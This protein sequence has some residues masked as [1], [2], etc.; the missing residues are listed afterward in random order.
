VA[1][2]SGTNTALVDGA[3][4]LAVKDLERRNRDVLVLWRLGSFVGV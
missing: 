2:D 1:V 3:K 4:M